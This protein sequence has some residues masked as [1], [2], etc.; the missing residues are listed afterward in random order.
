MEESYYIIM[1]I[2]A[3]KIEGMNDEIT[4]AVQNIKTAILQSQLRAVKLVN[5]EQLGLYFGIGRYISANTREGKWGTGAI[6]QISSWLRKEMPG[7]RG[8]G[9]TN[10]KNM[11]AFYEAWK[12][13]D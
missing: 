2:F 10:L 9:E 6:K 1:C 7:L 8:F 4:T 12:S 11:R 3:T 13:L 5:Q